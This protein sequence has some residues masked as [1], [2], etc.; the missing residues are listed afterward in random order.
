AGLDVAR[1]HS[2]DPSIYGAIAEQIRRLVDADIPYEIIPGV[3]AFAAAAAALGQELTIPGVAQ[4]LIL[5]RTS[6]K[7]SPMPAGEELRQL[8]ACRAT[9]AIHLSVRNSRSIQR[10]LIPCYGGD[11][12]VAIAYRVGWPDQLLVRTTLE[13]LHAQIRKAKI[14]RTALLIVG[15]ALAAK[16]FSDSSLYDKNHVHI[17]RH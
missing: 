13:Q 4:T 9:L 3:P 1:V 10:Q 6:M 17:L 16:D 14:T 5:T 7:S 15:W 2:G 8:G 11:C 12:P